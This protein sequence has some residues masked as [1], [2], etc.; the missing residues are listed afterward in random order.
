ML[1][2]ADTFKELNDALLYYDELVAKYGRI[3]GYYGN[4]KEDGK[5]DLEFGKSVRDKK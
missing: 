3:D 5:H 2:K 1:V 4:K